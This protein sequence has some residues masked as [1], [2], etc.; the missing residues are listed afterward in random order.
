MIN[1][2]EIKIMRIKKGIKAIELAKI[3]EISTTKLSLIENGHIQ[4]TDKL[5]KLII[6]ILNHENRKR[7]ENNGDILQE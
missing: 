2:T 4:C 3:L 5:Y 7:R 6:Q 1:G